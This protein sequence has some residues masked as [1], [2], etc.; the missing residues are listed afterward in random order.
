MLRFAGRIALAMLIICADTVAADP[1]ADYLLHCGGCHR[2]NGQGLPPDVPTLVDELG[3]L[4]TIPQGRSYLV[5]VPGA[6]QAPV[7]DQ[8]LADI[9][10]WILYEFNATT[11]PDDFKRLTAEEVGKARKNVLADPMKYRRQFWSDAE[12]SY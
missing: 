9:I 5:R 11:L 1:R 4:V 7:S 2:P 10:N 8:G 12:N 3:R 6:S